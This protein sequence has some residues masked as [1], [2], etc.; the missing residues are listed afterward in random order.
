MF[1]GAFSDE[2]IATQQTLEIAI[3]AFSKLDKRCQS[4]VRDKLDNDTGQLKSDAFI[5]TL[6]GTNRRTNVHTIGRH[7]HPRHHYSG[8]LDQ[9]F[10]LPCCQVVL[11]IAY[12]FK[13]VV[14]NVWYRCGRCHGG[15]LSH[16]TR[17]LG[18]CRANI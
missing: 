11:A 15:D 9:V 16:G 17:G 2:T 7:V 13:Q 5:A 14:W 10:A 8:K 4:L 1:D 12:K 6:E 3:L 18:A